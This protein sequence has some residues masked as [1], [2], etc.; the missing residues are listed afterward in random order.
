MKSKCLVLFFLSTCLLLPCRAHPEGF[1]ICFQQINKSSQNQGISS[2]CSGY[3]GARIPKWSSPFL[4]DTGGSSTQGHIYQ[5][6]IE[7]GEERKENRE[8]KLCFFQGIGNSNQCKGTHYSCTKV[9]SKNPSWTTPFRDSTDGCSY[10]WVI[11]SFP[12]SNPKKKFEVCRVCFKAE[13]QSQCRGNL[14]SCSS[15]AA[16]NGNRNPTWTRPF[17]D[18]TDRLSRGCIYTYSWYLDCTSVVNVVNC[19]RDTP[20]TTY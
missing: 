4:D 7:A 11:K 20:C 17:R 10:S 9:S 8:Y 15:W 14:E 2:A 1:R 13:G 6:R 16:V 19:P 18:N 3:S 12:N 5:W